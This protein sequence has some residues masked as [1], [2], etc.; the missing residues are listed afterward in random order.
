MEIITSLFPVCGGGKPFSAVRRRLLPKYFEQ[1]EE[2]FDEFGFRLPDLDGTVDP[3]AEQMPLESSSQRM[4]WLALIQNTHS[5]V[6][7]A[8]TWANVDIKQG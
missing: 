4:H 1:P 3:T 2:L 6:E 7:E 5:Q 8:L